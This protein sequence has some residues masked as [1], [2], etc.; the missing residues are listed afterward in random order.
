VPKTNW[1]RQYLANGLNTKMNIHE[2]DKAEHFNDQMRER[3]MKM[4]VDVRKLRSGIA[5]SPIDRP[6]VNQLIRSSKKVKLMN[7]SGSFRPSE[8]K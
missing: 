4:A 7:W 8:R 1:S 2:T 5:I 3:T 6:V